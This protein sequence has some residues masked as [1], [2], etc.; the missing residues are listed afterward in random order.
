MSS[1]LV[2]I[3][4]IN[5]NPN[6]TSSSDEVR[7]R[8]VLSL[9]IIHYNGTFSEID[10]DLEIPEFNWRITL[11][12][13]GYIVNFVNIY[14]LQKS[15][16]LVTYFNTSNPDDI[17]TYEEWGLTNV[18][19]EKG[20][21]RMTWNETYIEWQQYKMR[22]IQF[23]KVIRRKYLHVIA[24]VVGTIDEGYSII[25]GNSTN[26]T[27]SDKNNPLEIRAAVYVLTKGYHDKQFST[28]KMIYQLPLDNITI[29][30]ATCG[31]SS[32][33]I[34]QVCILT[35]TQNNV[36]YYVKL[37]FLSSGSITE[38]VPLN[39]T[40]P[41]LPQNATTGW[42]IESIP[43]GEPSAFNTRGTLI[44][45][46]NNTILIAPAESNNTWSLNTTDIPKFIDLD[47]V[48]SNFQ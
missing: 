4:I 29:S 21:I 30:D 45:L 19:P 18:N 32:T 17:T 47:N 8:P 25:M 48:Y 42:L 35:I 34:G 9:R 39:I 44:I 40:A 37:N 31:I 41:E 11:S 13:S 33:D 15:Y 46:P 20:F 28:P 23:N 26:S 24:T 22:Y 14:E 5:R 7:I 27:N 1:V 38:I 6:K 3:R 36:N 2:V 43:Y 10:K 12:S 16:L